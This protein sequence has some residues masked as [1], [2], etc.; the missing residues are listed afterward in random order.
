MLLT[1]ACAAIPHLGPKPMPSAETAF[2]SE[3][4][5]AGPVS[6]W[7]A[8]G[9]WRAYGD[10]QLDR[11]MEEAGS[12]SPDLAAAA[13]RLRAAEGYAQK[14]SAA[15]KPTI[16]GYAVADETKLSQ[17]NIVGPQATPNGFNGSAAAGISF[18][19]DLDLW[20][21]N[22]AALRAARADADAARFELEEAE[23][24][25]TTNIASTYA[26][27]AALYAQLDSDQDSLD[28][29]TQSAKLIAQR[30]QIGLDNQS[31]LEQA[32][33][34]VSQA[35][36]DIGETV[37]A[38][39]L[40]KNA[41]AAL[42]GAGPDRGLTIDRPQVAAL[43]PQGIPADASTN[44]IGRRPDIAAYRARVEAA[45]HRIKE[46]RAAFYP[47]VNLGALVGFQS[48]GIGNLFSNGSFT[49]SASPA[50]SLPLFHGGALQGQYRGR[51]GE[52]D[53]AVALYDGQVIDALKE[54][55]DALTSQQMLGRRLQD[56]RDALTHYQAAYKVATERYQHGLATYLDVLSAQEGVVNEQL[57]VASLETRAFT[58][59]VQLVRALGGGFATAT[60][61]D[62]GG[63]K[64]A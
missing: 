41:I 38:I 46:A 34:K 40:S 43:H 49:A 58:L 17:N 37:E 50:I 45:A 59:D 14:A 12:G 6:A 11:L 26:D 8:H 63:L 24:V 44:L 7:P 15:L 35:K 13:A 36:A 19:L 27:L 52:Y 39:K 53:E 4:A 9:W 54:T 18:S 62:S 30:V 2:K 21:K 29:R 16:D 64:A 20:G 47:S 60:T 51:R 10:P 23:L 32:N 5:L 48:F 25:L 28:I 57:K 33:A 56:S 55:A 31:S 42:A 1:S 3:K 61:Q 22:R